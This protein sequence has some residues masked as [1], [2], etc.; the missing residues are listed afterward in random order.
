MT[1]E[2]LSTSAP[3]SQPAVPPPRNLRIVKRTAVALWVFCAL[4]LPCL[5]PFIPFEPHRWWKI[6]IIV[7][8]GVSWFALYVGI[9]DAIQTN[10]KAG[11][12]QAKVAVN[13]VIP[14]LMSL[15]GHHHD[16]S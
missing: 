12:P 9:H 16:G 2:P 11:S 5:I 7:L 6:A 1:T 8:I 3:S 4:A 14:F 15:L 10:A 13:V